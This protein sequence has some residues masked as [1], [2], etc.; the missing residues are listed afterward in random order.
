MK[1]KRV[2]ADSNVLIKWFVPEDYSEHAVTLMNDHLL[3]HVEVVAPEYALLEF[4]N[5][6]RKYVVRGIMGADDALK[7]LQLLL[8]TRVNFVGIEEE[9]LSEALNYGLGNHVTV[10][11][12][13][14]VV[15]TRR[16][17]T[18]ML[19]ADERL[20]RKLHGMEPVIKHIKE[21][22]GISGKSNG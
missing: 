21:Y 11:D 6:L 10:Y 8:K 18:V 12:A 17:R 7:A 16:L 5:A 14:Y 1:A 9:L 20:L 15:L 22:R 4:T 2:V 13:Y 3:G 19:T